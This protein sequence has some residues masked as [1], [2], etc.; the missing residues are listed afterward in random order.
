MQRIF[1]FPIIK[2]LELI[3]GLAP[4][5]SKNSTERTRHSFDLIPF[6]APSPTS[7]V[8]GKNKKN[9][10]EGS[11]KA[12]DAEHYFCYII[13]D[14]RVRTYIR[15]E[16]Y[17][18]FFGVWNLFETREIHCKI[19]RTHLELLSAKHSTTPFKKKHN[20]SKNSSKRWGTMQTFV[21]QRLAV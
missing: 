9:A 5:F 11:Q 16:K 4:P 2:S 14:N 17:F 19:R 6:L 8:Y 18:L 3:L 13:S 1:S 20:F 10:A 7:V 21:L 15:S 12:A